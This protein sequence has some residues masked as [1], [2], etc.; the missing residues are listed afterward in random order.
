MLT[1][2]R[3]REMSREFVDEFNKEFC[4]SDFCTI[5]FNYAK[6][7][8]YFGVYKSNHQHI[9]ISCK[10]IILAEFTE[11]DLIA[12]LAHEVGHHIEG[13]LIYDFAPGRKY[14]RHRTGE[15][16][17]NNFAFLYRY[18]EAKELAWM[19]GD[20]PYLWRYDKNLQDEPNFWYKAWKRDHKKNIDI[21]VMEKNGQDFINIKHPIVHILIDGIKH[22]KRKRKSG[23]GVF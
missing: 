23:I 16:F 7:V 8:G 21:I 6:D 12:V 4:K 10:R 3:I 17:A 5:G 1:Y 15:Y 14:F 9:V 19:I 13:M 20:A 11:S 18:E 22:V 2:K